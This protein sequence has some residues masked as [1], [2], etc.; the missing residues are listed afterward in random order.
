MSEGPLFILAGNGAYPNRG[1]EAVVRGTAKIIRRQYPD[2]RFLCISHFKYKK[3][4]EEQRRNETDGGIEH[5]S[6]FHPSRKEA[7][8]S[9]YAPSTWKYVYRSLYNEERLGRSVYKGMVPYLKDAKAVLSIAA[10]NYSPYHGTSRMFVTLDDLVLSKDR[11]LVLWGASVGPFHIEPEHE[12][13]MSEHLKKATAIFARE[14]ATMR[15]MRRIGVA[16]NV[17]RTADPS[18]LLDAMRPEGILD[19]YPVYEDAI[20]L[21][22]SPRLAGHVTDGDMDAWTKM[23]A[24]IIDQVALRTELPIF[25]IPHAT[26][27]CSDDHAFMKSAL[28][29]AKKTEKVI[30]L[31]PTYSA[32]ET[33]WIISQM[34]VFAGARTHAVIDAISSCVPTLSLGYGMKTIGINHDAFGSTRYYLS[35]AYLTPERVA[36]RL[37]AMLD[38]RSAI[39]EQMIGR[40]RNLLNL[41][42]NSGA[43]LRAV[44]DGR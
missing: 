3:E 19:E 38:E 10:D 13:L 34:E 44:L 39:R 14:T 37:V 20:G 36:S 29:L 42:W 32:I 11:P 25:L 43:E 2:A 8:S 27:A 17:R 21:N 5:L 23:V 35:P 41:A 30:L 1:C 4:F 12:A 18:F 24:S 16:A 40:S 6:C 22:F 28:A 33:K 26:R 7:V 15:Y 31:P 9:F